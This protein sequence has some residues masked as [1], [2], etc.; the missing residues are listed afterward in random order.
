MFEPDGTLVGFLLADVRWTVRLN[1][2]NDIES[3]VIPR[4]YLLSSGI[5]LSKLAYLDDGW[6]VEWQ[7]YRYVL[8]NMDGDLETGLTAQ[9]IDAAT[10]GDAHARAALLELGPQ[11]LSLVA[12]DKGIGR[13]EMR[14]VQ[15]RCSIGR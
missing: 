8:Q 9:A 7:G 14:L 1:G 6:Y 4:E 5:S 13:G 10:L 11:T 12:K 2:S 15:G 3:I